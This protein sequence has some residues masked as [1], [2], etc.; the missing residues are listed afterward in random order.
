[1]LREILYLVIVTNVNATDTLALTWPSFETSSLLPLRGH[2]RIFKRE[3]I[4]PLVEHR[5]SSRNMM[6]SPAPLTPFE[7]E[8]L[9]RIEENK[10]RLGKEQAALHYLTAPSRA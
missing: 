5:V 6:H 1:M 9:K 10:K 4:R 2:E 7:L 8:R 3:L